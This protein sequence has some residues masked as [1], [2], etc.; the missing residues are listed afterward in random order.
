[1]SVNTVENSVA[2]TGLQQENVNQAREQHEERTKV[3]TYASEFFHCILPI[4]LIP[5][6]LTLFMYSLITSGELEITV[7]TVGA[8]SALFACILGQCLKPESVH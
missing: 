1:M 6:S 3:Q 2:N 5:A 7:L 4:L 8:A